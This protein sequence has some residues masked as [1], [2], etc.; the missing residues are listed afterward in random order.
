MKRPM[1]IV[2]YI[3]RK[4]HAMALASVQKVIEVPELL[5]ETPT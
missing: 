3:V 4:L 1:T 2:P 5:D